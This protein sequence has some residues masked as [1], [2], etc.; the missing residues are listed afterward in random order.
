[1]CK[2][3]ECFA[4]I[5]KIFFKINVSEQLQVEKRNPALSVTLNQ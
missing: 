5:K 3:V 4:Y 2:K 1:M